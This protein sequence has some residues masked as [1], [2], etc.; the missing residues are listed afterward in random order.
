MNILGLSWPVAMNP[1]AC[2]YR[3]G[4]L[5]AAAEEACLVRCEAAAYP[6]SFGAIERVVDEGGISFQEIDHFAVGHG[7]P[8][9]RFVNVLLEFVRGG[10]P[11]SKR[12]LEREIVGYVRHFT[13]WRKAKGRL[14]NGKAKVSLLPR[15]LARAARTFLLSDFEEANII[16]L[17]GRGDFESGI[18]AVGRGSQIEILESIPLSSNW[19][20]MCEQVIARLGLRSRFGAEEVM[21]LS[22]DGEGD[23]L[24][25]VDWNDPFPRIRPRAF[26]EFIASLPP[27]G[28][29]EPFTD[30]HR[31]TVASLQTTL[32]RA[33]LLISRHLERR[34]G[35]RSLCLAG[36][37][38]LTPSVIDA[39]FRGPYVDRLF[40][41]PA[42]GEV[43]TA[44]GAAAWVHAQ[45]TGR[46]PEGFLDRVHGG[47]SL[48]DGEVERVRF[49]PGFESLALEEHL[50]G[51]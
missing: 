1:A 26:R 39:L 14:K 21:A 8:H 49:G 6:W 12:E 28:T 30:E 37:T 33:L 50:F 46:R 18:L 5:V 31:T 25:F 24:P 3:D 20:R 2:L 42:S 36:G 35:V 23:V 29:D 10:L 43:G 27:R 17:G 34:T 47:A 41:Q 13:P 7:G 11:L 22:L 19:E 32:E 15:H 51:K 38:A 44:L 40:V 48:P 45:A 16:S 4:R 9:R